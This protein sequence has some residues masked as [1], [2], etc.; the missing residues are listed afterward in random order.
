MPTECQCCASS[1]LAEIDARL[2][3]GD[4]AAQVARKYKLHAKAVTR[5]RAKHLLR[6]AHKHALAQLTDS[7]VSLL[8]ATEQALASAQS[9]AAAS[10]AKGDTRGA[11]SASREVGRL[12]SLISM[13]EVRERAAQPGHAVGAH[14]PFAGEDPRKRLLRML[15]IDDPPPPDPSERPDGASGRF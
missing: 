10:L 5:H 4:S 7:P 3:A 11:L 15:H 2:S 9:L 12:L 8:C 14:A 1:R 13:L 6:L